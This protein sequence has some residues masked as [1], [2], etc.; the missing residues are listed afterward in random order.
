[1][2]DL[3]YI[4]QYYI[5]EAKKLAKPG[6]PWHTAHLENGIRGWHAT[7]LVDHKP[8]DLTDLIRAWGYSKHLIGQL[9]R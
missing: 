7:D 8:L 5:D 4:G 9:A 1:M 2:R 3:E 6:R